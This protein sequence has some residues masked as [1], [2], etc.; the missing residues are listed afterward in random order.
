M[1][2][3]NK[4]RNFVVTVWDMDCDFQG[5][6]DSG[7][8][9]FVA[10]GREICPDTKREHWQCYVAFENPRAHTPKALGK[11]GAMFGKIHARVKPM[12][13]SLAQNEAYCSKDGKFEKL[14]KEPK[15]GNRTDIHEKKDQIMNGEMTVDEICVENPE[16][17][18]QYG[19]TL[20]RLEGIALRKRFRTEMTEGVWY[21]G[22]S[23]CG[24]SH[25]CFKDYHPDTHYVKNLNEDWWDGYKGQPIVILNEFRGQIPFAELLDLVDKWPK[26]VKWRNREPVPFLAK[27]VIVASIRTPQDVYVNQK[28]EPWAQ[29][30]R[31]FRVETLTVFTDAIEDIPEQK[32]S[33]GNIITSE[34]KPKK[35]KFECDVDHTC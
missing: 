7:K 12:L 26:T 13:G 11:I 5:L 19:R 10:K 22:E 3:P 2:L 34:P 21:T 28:E 35:R 33:E 4:V 25:A 1:K 17:F 27:K 20:D 23:G 29:F 24:K 18:H 31:R 30:H 14:G 9:Q 8:I 16:F 6:I 32:C 15:Q